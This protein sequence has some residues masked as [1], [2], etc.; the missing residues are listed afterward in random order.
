MSHDQQKYAML[1]IQS[2]LSTTVAELQSK[3][4]LKNDLLRLLGCLNPLKK[5]NKSTQSSIEKLSSLLQP[6]L[7][8]SNKVLKEAS[9]KLEKVHETK[10]MSI[11]AVTVAQK[12]ID[13][14]RDMRDDAMEK[15]DEIRMK[16]KITT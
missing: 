9:A 10:P 1:G 5:N 2:F 3:L 6:K 13:T 8:I 14:A 11:S 15:L 4:P 16:Q 7:N 12:V